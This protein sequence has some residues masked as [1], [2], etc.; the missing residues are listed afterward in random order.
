MKI[1]FLM[2]NKLR[3]S[4]FNVNGFNEEYK[5]FRVTALLDYSSPDD[6]NEHIIYSVAYE[7]SAI[8]YCLVPADITTEALS[9]IFR[10][11][12]FNLEEVSVE[13]VPDYILIN[14]FIN[15]YSCSR[16]FFL[17]RFSFWTSWHR[18][19]KSQSFS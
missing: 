16:S 6:G 4:N 14:L 17:I 15:K 8:F 10:D 3:F 12:K 19:N 5:V 2:I 7:T 1:G 9:D 13:S 11:Y 18:I